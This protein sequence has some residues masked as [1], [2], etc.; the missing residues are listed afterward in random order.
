MLPISLTSFAKC[1]EWFL[2]VCAAFRATRKHI[3]VAMSG[4]ALSAVSDQLFSKSDLRRLRSNGGNEEIEDD[5]RHGSACGCAI[6]LRK[7]CMYLLAGLKVSHC[8][9][10]TSRVTYQCSVFRP[11]TPTSHLR[12]LDDV[13]RARRHGACMQRKRKKSNV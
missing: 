7:Q 4:I 13:R 8:S 2:R 1:I 10:V 5:M 11:G 9:I 3:A 6:A 12:R